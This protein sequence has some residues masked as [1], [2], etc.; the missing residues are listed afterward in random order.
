[1]AVNGFPFFRAQSLLRSGNDS[2]YQRKRRHRGCRDSQPV[3]YDVL[4]GSVPESSRTCAYREP[5]EM[6][7]D[8]L[9]EIIG[10]LVPPLRFL[11]KRLEH[12]ILQIAPDPAFRVPRK[13][14][15]LAANGL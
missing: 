9:R 2:A 11:A 1:M 5:F 4:R 13:L 7:P 6:S 3:A 15:L 12:D 14:R 8:V 10:R